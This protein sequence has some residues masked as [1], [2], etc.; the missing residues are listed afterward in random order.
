MVAFTV[1]EPLGELAT[2]TIHP[3]IMR[4]R[5]EFI[6]AVRAM[7]EERHAR[8]V[9]YTDFAFRSGY[10]VDHPLYWHTPGC[11]ACAN[12]VGLIGLGLDK[13]FEFP[14][15]GLPTLCECLGVTIGFST[16]VDSENFNERYSFADM[17]NIMERLLVSYTDWDHATEPPAY[18]FDASRID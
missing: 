15:D 10:I 8:F 3:D 2:Q 18:T 5:Q 9:Y 6:S 12:G 16:T 1:N 14:A 7:D 13:E 11:R 17:A 4:N